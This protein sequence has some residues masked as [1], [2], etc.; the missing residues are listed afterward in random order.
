MMTR[1][2]SIAA[3]REIE[4]N[5]LLKNLQ[6]M[7]YSTLFK[8]GPLTANE[9][10]LKIDAESNS[11]VYSTRLSEL[12]R[13]GVVTRVD[14]RPCTV[15]GKVAYSWDVTDK[16]PKDVIPAKTKKQ[17]IADIVKKGRLLYG[18]IPK[19]HQQEFVNLI[20]LVKGL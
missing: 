4:E 20:K 17:K 10:R 15:T 12:E 16:L 8:Q 13:K 3:F 9:M 7:V 14:K 1:S 5:G 11:G 18:K 6:F 19:Q 2:T